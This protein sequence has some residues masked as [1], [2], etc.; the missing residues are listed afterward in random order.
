MRVHE[1]AK[2]LKITSGELIKKLKSLK[3]KV[4]GHMSALDESVVE[5]L[6][7]ELKG[8]KAKKEKVP[9]EKKPAKAKKEE[10]SAVKKKRGR[11]R[12]KIEPA[13]EKVA[14]PP[15]K[16]VKEE[17]H[18][19]KKPKPPTKH[20]EEKVV[21]APVQEAP[22]V[23]KLKEIEL[24]LPISVK[25][26][27]VKLQQKPSIVMKSLIQMGIFVSINQTLS[28][29]LVNKILEKF[30]LQ[31]KKLPTEEERMVE[32]H[33]QESSEKG[34]LSFRSPVVTFMGHVDHGKT[35]LLDLI[36]KTKVA[37]R[38]HGG[39]TQHVGAYRVSLDKGAIT[40]L[41]TPGHE[42]F[43]AMRARGA[44]ITDA[45]VLVVAA[46]EGV[47]PQTIEAINHS[48]AAEVPIIVAL[49]K[50]DRPS[51]D[52]DKVKKQLSE[53]DLASEDWG[54]KT[55]TVGVSAKTGEGIDHLLEMILLE[56][57]MLELKA[58]HDKKA[59]GAVVEAKMSKGKG[60]LITAI[61]HD[62]TLHVGDAVVV[63][64]YYGKVKALLDDNEE[65]ISEA[66]PSMPVEILGINGV[67]EAGEQFYVVED[68]RTARDIFNRRQAQKKKEQMQPSA[69]LSLDDIYV[70]IKEG[71]VKEVP[72]IVKAD[73][74]GSLEAL[75]D[76]LGKIP[77]TEVQLK[78]IHAGVGV[79]NA[80]DVVL[81]SASNAI[82]IGFHIDIAPAAAV[83][84]EKEG[85]DIRSYRIIY[86]AINDIRAALEGM[87]E[88]KVKKTFVARA[89]IKQVFKLSKHGIVAGCTVQKGKITRNLHAELSRNGEVVHKGKLS[90]LK[91]FKDDVREVAEGFECGMTLDDFTDYRQG[92]II[93]FYVI[94]KIAR[95]LQ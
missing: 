93:D 64:S 76:S 47:M 52:I 90:S 4:Q 84:A 95:K 10:S 32:D 79:I 24:K 62:G 42:A 44:N 69:K 35:S 11:P 1:L 57:E 8:A 37:E 83:Q 28:E 13:E 51:A 66:G 74:Q 87:L 14:A 56:A 92:D 9:K 49:N 82:I 31:L 94:E 23:K 34:S 12:K 40:F 2:E 60:S 7:K 26:L 45:V 21:P 89:G 77:S 88:P 5:K 29:E 36:R 19:V 85:V 38:E 39:I 63:G 73:V 55:I 58:N 3:I 41:D 71:K 81:A 46:D 18:E 91:R 17:P 50:I 86:D 67:P 48:R 72:L 54:G 65:N 61:V 22:S 75:K 70:Q 43:T 68:E 53:L 15:I 33:R 80:S 27:S 6:R 78:I 25:E 20:I 16:E 59:S 30:E